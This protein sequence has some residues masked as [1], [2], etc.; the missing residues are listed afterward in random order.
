MYDKYRRERE[1][2]KERERER[3]LK[4]VKTDLIILITDSLMLLIVQ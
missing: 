1:R 3:V 4:G 2:E